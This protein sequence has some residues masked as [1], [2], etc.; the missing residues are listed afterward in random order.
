MY[1][2]IYLLIPYSFPDRLFSVAL[3]LCA[4]R[5]DVVLRFPKNSGRSSLPKEYFETETAMKE[6]KWKK[7]RLSEDIRREQIVL[8]QVKFNYEIKKQE[9][10]KYLAESSSHSTQV[11][12]LHAANNCSCSEYFHPLMYS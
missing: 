1:L 5:K 2:R 8:D 10:V 7:E 9:F 11:M 12:L 4:C 6:E 3:K